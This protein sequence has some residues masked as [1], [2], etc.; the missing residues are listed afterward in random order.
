[1]HDGI[2]HRADSPLIPIRPRICPDGATA[3]KLRIIMQLV[4]AIIL[5]EI[6]VL[7]T[8]PA[9]AQTTKELNTVADIYAAIRACWKTAKISGPEALGVRLSF[10]RDGKILGKARVT[11]ES[12]TATD[13]NRLR[14]RVAVMNAFKRCTPLSFSP[15]LGDA[16]AGRPF[17]FRFIS[18]SGSGA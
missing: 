5:V 16:V 13:E 11:Y 10:T 2:L 18:N 3:R 14:F 4:R 17:N 9:G 8:G 7:L 6:V 1:M 15:G 12:K